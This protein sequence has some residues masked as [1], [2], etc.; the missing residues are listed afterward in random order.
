MHDPIAL[1]I[2]TFFVAIGVE[3]AIARKKGREVYRLADAVTD[4][5]CGVTSQLAN[6]FV[7]AMLLAAYDKVYSGY[8]L[9]TWQS[10]WVV[11]TLAFFG[12]DFL[13]YWWHRLSHE[14]NV[15]WAAHVVHHQSEDYNLAVALRQAVVT[16]FTFL[17]FYLPLAFL[18]VPT[19]VYA[20]MVAISTLYQF[21][22]HTELVPVVRGPLG[23]VLNLPS[24]HRVHHARDAHYL[25]KNYA[26]ILIVW[27]RLFGTFVEESEPPHYGLTKPLGT[28]SPLWAQVH[29]FVELGERMWKLPR[30]SDKLL[31]PFRSPAWQGEGEEKHLP[32]VAKYD[33]RVSRGTQVYVVVQYFLVLV[34]AFLVLFYKF[35]ASLRVLALS[36]FAVLFGVVSIGAL[37]ENKRWARGLEAARLLV[38]AGLA[39]LVLRQLGP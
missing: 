35:E 4:L 14:V 38:T 21:W 20:I 18:G 26:A 24:H 22:I 12:V 5:S 11:W 30:L 15:L 9:V 16:H 36:S 13:Y 29:Y 19:L 7:G 10:S 8:R 17:P 1:A 25:D 34:G 33:V 39:V 31:L 23:Y 32:P 2:P 6:V 37:L 3:Y 27:D 28:F